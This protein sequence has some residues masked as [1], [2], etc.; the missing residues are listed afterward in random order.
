MR[1]LT[2][3]LEFQN[4]KFTITREPILLTGGCFVFFL[5]FC[6]T[7]ETLYEQEMFYAVLIIYVFTRVS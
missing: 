7:G 3:E 2:L 1:V 5:F 6:F 4:E